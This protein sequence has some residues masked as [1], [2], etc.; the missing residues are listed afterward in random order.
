MG[1]TQEIRPVPKKLGQARFSGVSNPLF[2]VARLTVFE[3]MRVFFLFQFS[4]ITTT[5]SIFVEIGQSLAIIIFVLNIIFC[6]CFVSN[7]F[8]VCRIE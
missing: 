5:N 7:Q 6:D 2:S 3:I 8:P 4:I 1:I